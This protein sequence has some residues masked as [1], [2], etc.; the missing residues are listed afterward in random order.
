MRQAARMGEVMDAKRPMTCAQ[1]VRQFFAYLDRA[2]GGE[3]LESFEGHLKACYDCCDRLQFSQQL[4]AFVKER[5]G[6]S[7][8]PEGLEERLRRSLVRARTPAPDPHEH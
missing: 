5:V 2:L 6:D 4:D 7:P 1:A 8:L 3:E